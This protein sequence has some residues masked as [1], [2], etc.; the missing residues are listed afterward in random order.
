MIP[1]NAIQ[2]MITDDASQRGAGVCFSRGL[3]LAGE[4]FARHLRGLLPLLQDW[5]VI[6]S[7]TFGGISS[8][9]V[10]LELLQVDVVRHVYIDK[11]RNCQQVVSQPFPDVKI[12]PNICDATCRAL[13]RGLRD[14]LDCTVLHVAGSPFSDNT[15][16]L[17]TLT[18][19]EWFVQ[20]TQFLDARY[21]ASRVHWWQNRQITSQRPD[22]DLDLDQG[23]AIWI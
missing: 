16:K 17:G 2:E 15:S 20:I 12:I 14:V 8:V 1:Q 23:V 11:D 3:S 6:L 22:P 13:D 4:G 9:R 10:A 21:G 5:E 19:L 7:D 18:P